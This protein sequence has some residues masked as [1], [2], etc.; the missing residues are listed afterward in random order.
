MEWILEK[1][2]ET[3]TSERG[4][5]VDTLEKRVDLNGSLSKG[6]AW[7]A[8]KQCEDDKGNFVSRMRPGGIAVSSI[9]LTLVDVEV[10]MMR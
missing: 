8:R 7:H 1:L 10:R 2:F 9:L 6:H 4:I 3:S 5:E